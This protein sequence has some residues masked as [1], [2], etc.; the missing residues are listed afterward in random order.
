MQAI[1]VKPLVEIEDN[2]QKSIY[3]VNTNF[4]QAL[5]ILTSELIQIIDK[6]SAE[7]RIKQWVLQ[8]DHT[9]QIEFATK[10]YKLFIVCL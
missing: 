5:Q 1:K 7:Q 3:S 9:M 8:K 2:P 4:N 10:A 6:D